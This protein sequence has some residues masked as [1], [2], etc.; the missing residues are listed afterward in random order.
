[1]RRGAA[2][3]GIALLVMVGAGCGDGT[4]AFCEPLSRQADM[5]RLSAALDAGD[6][7]KAQREAARFARLAEE[8]PDEVRPDLKALA[9]GVADVVEVLQA[10]A[11]GGDPAAVERQRE[12][13][14]TRLAE[15]GRR[16]TSVQ[17]WASRECGLEL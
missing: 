14:N 2:T 5:A 12:E 13:L 11:A 16:S 3:A 7:A 4:P 1:M 9:S 6:L 17:T 10:D 15:L 8:A